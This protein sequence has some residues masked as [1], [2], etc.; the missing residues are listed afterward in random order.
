MSYLA[1]TLP[2]HRLYL[3]SGLDLLLALDRDVN[4]ENKGCFNLNDVRSQSVASVSG[5]FL[6]CQMARVMNIET[7]RDE[8]HI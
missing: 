5:V 4:R 8:C 2:K 1:A 7:Q 3:H 6:I